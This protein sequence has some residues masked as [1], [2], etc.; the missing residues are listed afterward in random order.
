VTN[1]RDEQAAARQALVAMASCSEAQALAKLGSGPQGLDANEAAKRLAQG[2]PNSVVAERGAGWFGALLARLAN[3]LNILLLVLSG[4]SLATGNA[5]SAVIIFL[6]VVLSITLG[7][8]QERR[9]GKAAAALRAMV[10][11]TAT[12]WR[13]VAVPADHSELELPRLLRQ[14]IGA[15][16]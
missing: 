8:V 12:V 4:V 6:M 7:L 3:P 1:I 10:H 9:S 14:R 13:P 11:T 5:Q 16:G 2:G 15:D